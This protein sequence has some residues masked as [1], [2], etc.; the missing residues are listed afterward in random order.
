[1]VTGDDDEEELTTEKVRP[2]DKRGMETKE[3]NRGRENRN[4][5]ERKEKRAFTR[6]RANRLGEVFRF[7]REMGPPGL[8]CFDD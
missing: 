8:P 5:G 6:D 4:E 2:A 1:M 3:S 7:I